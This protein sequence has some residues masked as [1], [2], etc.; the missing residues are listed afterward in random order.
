MYI[1]YVCVVCM[2]YTYMYVY[3]YNI[4]YI[5]VPKYSLFS[6]YYATCMHVFGADYLALNSQLIF[7]PP[8][9]DHLFHFQ[10]PSVAYNSLWRVEAQGLSPIP[11][12]ILLVSSL[13]GH[14]NETL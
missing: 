9:E 1:P 6:L 12:G 11:F 7:L 3:I 2:V 8:G 4:Y 10:L 14:V 5:Y 13:F